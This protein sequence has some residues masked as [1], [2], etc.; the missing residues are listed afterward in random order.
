MKTVKH[1]I[2][3]LLLIALTTFAQRATTTRKTT[4][5]PEPAKTA[6][7]AQPE[8]TNDLKLKTRIEMQSFNMDSTVYIKGE[9][10][11]TEQMMPG[12]NMQMVT[13]KE[14]DLRRTIQ[15]NDSA[16]VYRIEPFNDAV[17]SASTPPPKTTT[18]PPPTSNKPT[19]KGGVVTI[20]I[21]MTDTGERKEMFGYQARHLK[22]AMSFSASPDACSKANMRMETDG[23]YINFRNNFSCQEEFVPRAALERQRQAKPDCVDEWRYN[24]QGN[25]KMGYPADV[26]MTM[27]GENGKPFTMRQQILELSRAKLDQALFEIPPGYQ[28][29]DPYSM[30]AMMGGV[31]VGSLGK[32]ADEMA[33]REDART[34]APAEKKAGVI[35]LGVVQPAARI[36]QTEVGGAIR[37]TLI[38]YLS[39][40]ATL[41]V[42]PLNSP[43]EAASNQCDFVLTSSLSYQAGKGGG[44]GGFMKKAGQLGQIASG[45]I[46][47][48]SGGASVPQSAAEAS[49]QIKSKDEVG[50]EYQLTRVNGSAVT[51]NSMKRKSNSDGEDVI[52]PLLSQAAGEIMRAVFKK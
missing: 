39:G 15:I 48:A 47:G 38:K 52:S 14:C 9:R 23:W 44:F 27:Y 41:E 46:P 25:V 5:A 22:M 24:V 12:L 1:S 13:I 43:A 6:Q 40:G 8:T 19:R 33:K 16:K 36:G 21:T 17:S 4:T 20:N 30:R 7:P 3:L 32:L 11:R 42:I 28:E 31:N 51:S 49:N 35:R 37:N 2:F 10:E 34:S 26:T 18:A 50:Y 29:G 45:N